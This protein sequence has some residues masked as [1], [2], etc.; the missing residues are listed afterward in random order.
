MG[1]ARLACAFGG[2]DFCV[3]L[4]FFAGAATVADL[5]LAEYECVCLRDKAQVSEKQRRC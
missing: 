5:L 2:V 3:R 1:G 4:C